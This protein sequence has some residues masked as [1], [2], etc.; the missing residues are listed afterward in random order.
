MG[1][2]Y[3]GSPITQ[4]LSQ[5]PLLLALKYGEAA[6]LASSI[7]ICLSPMTPHPHPSSLALEP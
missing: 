2:F 3:C 6:H 5:W 7:L 4:E 1:T